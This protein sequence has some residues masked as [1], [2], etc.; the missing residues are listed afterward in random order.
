MKFEWHQL[1]CILAFLVSSAALGKDYTQQECPVVGNLETRIYHVPGDR[2][3]WQMLRENKVNRDNRACFKSPAE[4]EK[5]GY[6]RS[7][8]GKGK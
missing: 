6:L 2:N 1:V 4:A 5:A 3:Y 7:R 8:S